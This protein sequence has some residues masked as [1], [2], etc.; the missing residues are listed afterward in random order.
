[1][2]PTTKPPVVLV[3]EDEA[4]VRMDISDFLTDAGYRVIAEV[5]PEHALAVLNVRSDIVVLVTDINMPGSLNGCALAR[6]VELRW[7]G[8]RI[9]ATSGKGRPAPGE[10]PGRALF[11]LKP[12]TP[13]ALLEAV[14]AA[15]RIYGNGG[16]LLGEPGGSQEPAARG[17]RVEDLGNGTARVQIDEVVP[18]SVAVELLDLL[19]EAAGSDELPSANQVTDRP[20]RDR[21]REH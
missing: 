19:R 18:W 9:I 11:L 20:G 16:A 17:P 1:M 4:L 13:S 3:V 15:G 10:L 2:S 5:S 7:P 6:I 21:A 14:R 8:I 12:Y